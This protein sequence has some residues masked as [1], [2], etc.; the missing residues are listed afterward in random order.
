MA[1]SA[2]DIISLL[3]YKS[4]EFF[5]ARGQIFIISY[6]LKEDANVTWKI[7]TPDNNLIR[8]LKVMDQT[9][10]RHTLKWDGKDENGTVV[11]DE[12]Y[13]IVLQA[14]NSRH[15]SILDFRQTGG[16]VL[17]N[18]QTKVDKHGNISY[19]L[20][21]PARVLVRA[22]IENGPMLRVIS[23]WVPK[24]RGKIRQRWDMRDAD[25]LVDI[26][27]LPFGITVSAFTLPDNAIIATNNKKIDY[28]TYFKQNNLSCG[29]I[30]K[31]EQKL[32]KNGKPISKHSYMCRIQDRDPR[33]Y[34]ELENRVKNDQNISVLSNDEKVLVKV[35]MHPEDEAIM[36]Q[37]KYEVSF[38]MDFEFTSEEE[39][40]YMPIKWNFIPNGFKK[41]IHI[42][43]VNISSFNG[44]V[45]LKSYK[46]FVK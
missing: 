44:Q 6:D 38:F 41:G 35:S 4:N 14:Q 24:N 13:S 29:K 18:L 25:D 31:K 37:S 19:R 36:E 11:P 33:L 34:L 43:T 10:G 17:K 40:G 16:V 9:K 21:S 23:N 22:G 45:G 3:P 28:Y 12:A 8:T 5:P 20:S 27:A 7:Y 26:S 30:L 42:L 1:L 39:L 2:K 46:L 32:I 15:K